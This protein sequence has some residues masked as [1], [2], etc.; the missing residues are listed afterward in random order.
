MY[1]T[2]I[3]LLSEYE[4]NVA[5]DKKVGLICEKK[6][7]TYV[8]CYSES[9][10]TKLTQYAVFEEYIL[11]VLPPYEPVQV[12]EHMPKISFE[13]FVS[14]IASLLGL[15]FGFSVIMFTDFCLVAIKYIANHIFIYMLSKFVAKK[16]IIVI[17]RTRRFDVERIEGYRDKI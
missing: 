17:N 15:Y 4:K 13:E 10:N 12:I 3:Y 11:G 9:Y 14:F 7:K 1:M 5:I 8:D 2:N 6:C 16:N